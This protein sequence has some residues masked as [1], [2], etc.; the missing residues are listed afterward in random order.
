MKQIISI[1]MLIL[2]SFSHPSVAGLSDGW[3]QLGK[4]RVNAIKEYDE[5]RLA[6]KGFIKQLAI[7]VRGS[8]VYFES[9]SVH[10]GDGQVMDIP[11]RS[12][13]KAGERS[14]VI[15]LPGTARIINKVVFVHQ[16]LRENI[17]AEVVLW[18]RK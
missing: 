15:D 4:E 13:I 17:K 1:I 18:G 6:S 8:A 10:L 2:L 16:K 14:R 9:V 11:I 5:M 7:E 12:L 3:Q